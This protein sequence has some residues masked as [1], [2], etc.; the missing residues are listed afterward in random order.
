MR[1]AARD[2]ERLKGDFWTLLRKVGR[3]LPFA[4][5]VLAAFYCA[6]DPTTERRVK[7]ILLG[8]IGYFVLPVDIIPDVLPIIG[9]TDDAAVI[10]TAL[11]TVAR[12]MKPEHRERA[13][14]TLDAD[15]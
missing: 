7:L 11:S 8:A 3:K 10:A 13:R 15:V 9:F 1:R 5:D 14:E 4:E 6:T 12:A 2:E